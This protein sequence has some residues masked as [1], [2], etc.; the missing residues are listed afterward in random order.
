MERQ[1]R[2][3]DRRSGMGC[4]R[5]HRAPRR[6]RLPGARVPRRKGAGE[7]GFARALHA[8]TRGSA[9]LRIADFV[10]EG[11]GTLWDIAFSTGPAPYV[12]WMLV[13]ERAEG[14]DV[15]AQRIRD[16]NSLRPRHGARV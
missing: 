3:G 16:D 4:P 2:A 15:L 1:P 8:G 14:G 13:E 7:H 12:G 10:N 5:Q 11:N 6:H 9:G